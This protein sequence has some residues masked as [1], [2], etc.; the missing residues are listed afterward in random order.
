M[1]S[2]NACFSYFPLPQ[3]GLKLYTEFWIP[4]KPKALIVVVHGLSEHTGRYGPLIKHF[5]NLGYAVAVYDQRGHGQSE[6]E[7]G[8]IASFQDL[9]SDLAAFLEH[10]R[11]RFPDLPLFLLGHSLGGQIALNFVVKYRMGL[12]G[13]L[14]S[15]PNLQLKMKIPAW[16]RWFV[17]KG[18]QALPKLKMGSEIKPEELS[19][20][21][22]VVEGY[23]ADP[24]VIRRYSLQSAWE[25]LHNLD[26]VMAM[27]P[28]IHVPVFFAHAGDDSITDPEG[29]RQFYR[30]VPVQRKRMR[31]YSGFYHEL[32][33]EVGKEQVF[34]DMNKFMEDLLLEDREREQHKVSHSKVI[35]DVKYQ[36]SLWGGV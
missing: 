16:K 11:K 33:H 28:R 24:R 32:V 4:Q 18:H 31:I 30:R 5:Y 17:E 13:V 27:A 8:H 36:Q 21:M 26:M 34:E 14:V 2:A 29:T 1:S 12:R 3:G 15:S 7:R 25:I 9:L 23:K 6:G 35:Q 10:V 20:D 22:F 19:H